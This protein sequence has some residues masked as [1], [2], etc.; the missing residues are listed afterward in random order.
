[1]VG[2]PPGAESTSNCP[3][4]RGACVAERGPRSLAHRCGAIVLERRAL[5]E[6]ESSGAKPR[7]FVL[8]GVDSLTPAERRVATLAADGLSNPEI[9]QTLYVT[10]KTVE[11]HLGHVC[12]KLEIPGRGE[13]ADALCETSQTGVRM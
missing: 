2:F 12:G 3:A 5:A 11:T 6:L 8:S 9:A 10:R 13:L 1:M 7:R 4:N